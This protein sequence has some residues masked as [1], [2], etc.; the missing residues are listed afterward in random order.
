MLSRVVRTATVFLFFPFAF[1][2]LHSRSAFFVIYFLLIDLSRPFVDHTGRYWSVCPT[3]HSFLR[4]VSCCGP[5][6]T[7]QGSHPNKWGQG[8]SC[9]YLIRRWQPLLEL[10]FLP[11]SY[12]WPIRLRTSFGMLERT[13][14]GDVAWTRSSSAV[15]PSNLDSLCSSSGISFSS[16][17]A[18]G[19]I[20]NGSESLDPLAPQIYI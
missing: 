1:F 20:W 19:L 14:S 6:R 11:C 5:D 18:L 17:W 9:W 7:V 2:L 13:A 8:I 16:A 10:L 4:S 15:Y 12:D 3:N